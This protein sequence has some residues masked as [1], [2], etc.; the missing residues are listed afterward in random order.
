MS[1]F[2]G[3]DSTGIDS[4]KTLLGT[5][6]GCRGCD[7]HAITYDNL[8]IRP[9]TIGTGD[10]LIDDSLEFTTDT[11]GLSIL[12]NLSCNHQLWICS[13][14]PRLAL[15]IAY[16]TAA[17]IMAHALYSASKEQANIRSSAN[18]QNEK[19]MNYYQGKADEYLHSVLQGVV[20]PEDD[21][22]FVCSQQVRSLSFVSQ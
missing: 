4:V 14:A 2:I 22:C 16:Q 11:G 21:R 3:Y 18:E 1:G 9:A 5:P 20:L 17:E 7:S 13:I 10:Q 6:S 15:G 8:H 19:R 12:F